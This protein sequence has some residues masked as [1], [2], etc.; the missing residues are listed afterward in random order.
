MPAKPSP[1]EPANSTLQDARVFGRGACVSLT[2]NMAARALNL[3][4]QAAMA[5][6]LGAANF[7]I[8]SLGWTLVRTFPSLSTLGVEAGVT[9]F[10]AGYLQSDRHSFKTIVNDSLLVAFVSGLT[11][12][13][14]IY[15]SAPFLASAVFHKPEAISVIRGFSPAFPL[16]ALLIVGNNVTALSHHMQ[17]FVYSSLALA[18]SILIFFC[19]LFAV[20]FGVMGAVFSTVAG[21]AV[22]AVLSACFIKGLFPGL[23]TM[24]RSA[25]PL[26]RQLLTYSTPLILP[27]IASS[28]LGLVDRLFVASLCT[29]TELG[30]YQ[31]ASQLAILFLILHGAFNSILSPMIADLHSRQETARLLELYR[32][33]VKWAFYSAIPAF[34]TILFASTALVR[35]IY[36]PAYSDANV[37]LIILSFGQMVLLGAAAAGQMLL[38]TGRQRAYILIPIAVLPFDV[39]C[40]WFFAATM[41]P[42]GAAAAT[43]VCAVIL[44]AAA[45]ITVRLSL[46][47]WP[48]DARS[49]KTLI[50][51][52]CTL[53]LLFACRRLKIEGSAFRLAF[54]GGVSI[55]GFFG[56][57]LACGLD[58]EDRTLLAVFAQQLEP[59]FQASRGGSL[60]DYRA[61]RSGH[62]THSA[63]QS[64]Q[65]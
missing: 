36:G 56:S 29:S 23:L 40:T 45:V 25:R 19:I 26:C 47:F 17:Y 32:I 63:G 6:L 53:A 5:R 44:A 10:G 59:F 65:K 54:F 39:L 3:G 55:T 64:S 22:G 8:Y 11:I 49:P 15:L 4:T 35:F 18:A 43:A 27:G 33:S 12:G 57:L 62:G 31:A 52:L 16:Y 38:M 48:F 30:V 28:L 7:G 51:T 37:P 21:I 42:T 50:A 34:L 1:A 24:R 13:G 41:G 20:G 2:G 9:Y 58:S 61:R 60:S 46:G 14:I